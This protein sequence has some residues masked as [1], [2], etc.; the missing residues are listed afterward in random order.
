MAEIYLIQYSEKS[1]AV[2]GNTKPFRKELYY[3]G[4]KYNRNLTDP[5]T[6][7]KIPGWIFP[8]SKTDEIYEHVYNQF[9]DLV[10]EKKNKPYL[11]EYSDKKIAIFGNTVSIYK[12]LENLGGGRYLRG[13]TH[14]G[15]QVSG[16]IFPK[17]I[18]KEG[19]RLEKLKKLLK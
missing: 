16:W 2:L 14:N 10:I 6:K 4:G 7:E 8:N 5:E 1:I 19:N 9:K 15:K 17:R 13:L 18:L 11:V 12:D 3:L